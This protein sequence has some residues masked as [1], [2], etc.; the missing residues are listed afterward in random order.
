ML[1]VRGRL[2]HL[3]PESYNIY[4]K[5]TDHEY[6]MMPQGAAE[7]SPSLRSSAMATTSAVYHSKGWRS[8]PV[9][10]WRAQLKD[11]KDKPMLSL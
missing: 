8:G 3:R 10:V 4:D 6:S 5:C 11:C 7:S 1:G 2:R 9:R